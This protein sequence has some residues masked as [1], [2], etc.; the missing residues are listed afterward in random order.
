ML[1]KRI[2]FVFWQ[3]VRKEEKNSSFAAH[4]TFSFL[5]TLDIDVPYRALT[6]TFETDL[7]SLFGLRAA[8]AALRPKKQASDDLRMRRSASMRCT[9]S[10]PPSYFDYPSK[11][12]RMSADYALEARRESEHTAP[13]A[14]H[15]F[16]STSSILLADALLPM[17]NVVIGPAGQPAPPS[18]AEP[19]RS[20]LRFQLP[21]TPQR[22]HTISVPP[23]RNNSKNRSRSPL[24][25][26]RLRLSTSSSGS[27][28]ED[29]ASD[30]ETP[31]RVVPMLGTKVELLRRPLPMQGVI[32]YIGPVEFA[33]G[34]YVGIELEKRCKCLFS[35]FLLP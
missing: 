11:A 10:T 31:T 35:F 13:P 15:R 6:K 3:K 14:V 24:H 2:F 21:E 1:S 34:T 19:R 4:L 22:Y 32:K 8:R 28:S 12:P 20:R 27:S 17:D 33:K 29:N 26:Y 18:T 30:D 23:T 5:F 25:K 7:A 16:S 9:Q